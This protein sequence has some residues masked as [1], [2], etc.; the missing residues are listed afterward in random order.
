MLVGGDDISHKHNAANG[1]QA[2]M[3][4]IAATKVSLVNFRST[5]VI[6]F[7]K[8]WS[9]LQLRTMMSFLQRSIWLVP[10]SVAFDIVSRCFENKNNNCWEIKLS[11]NAICLLFTNLK[12]HNLATLLPGRPSYRVVRNGFVINKQMVFL[13]IFISQ[14]LLFYF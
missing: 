13:Q 14:L 4:P 7:S 5:R 2:N 9:T 6:A 10:Q 12:I 11:K 3:N 1:V 8:V